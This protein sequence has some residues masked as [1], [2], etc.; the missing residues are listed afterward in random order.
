MDIS[1]NLFRDVV[2]DL[3]CP[4]THS[5]P[6]FDYL[7]RSNRPLEEN[8]RI[9]LENWFS[10][11]PEDE[12]YDLASSFRSGKGDDLQPAFFELALHELL[13]NLESRINV[14]PAL[15]NTNNK[16]DFFVEH[17]KGESFFLEALHFDGM[18]DEEVGRERIKDK[19]YD[20]LNARIAS[21]NHF[22]WINLSGEPTS[23][24]ACRN[25][26]P[27]LQR[28]I[29]IYKRNS[30]ARHVYQHEGLRI[31]FSLSPK[32]GTSKGS[33]D[34]RP[35]GVIP[36]KN[37]GS[38]HKILR[39]KLHDKARKYGYCDKPFIIAVSLTSPYMGKEDIERVLSY[40]PD[41]Q[42]T[43]SNVAFRQNATGLW[44]GN[45]QTRYTR[46]SGI[47]GVFGLSPWVTTEASICF[48]HNPFAALPISSSFERLP[49]AVLHGDHFV[50]EDGES[51]QT[52]LRM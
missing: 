1:M 2:R 5:R 20:E 43:D 36:V 44:V 42:D 40:L 10:R 6:S 9:R 23:Q 34:I 7:N 48:Y 38:K 29:D 52:L 28:F 33:T 32:T 3:E 47:L 35:I 15:P 51:L 25:Y 16:P 22:I 17:A 26:I 46:V 8:I 11:Y 41:R 37:Y 13:L 45:E 49:Q 24:P 27:D 31:E 12:Q 14:H 19:I 30:S 50:Y 39:G 18:S 4:N 21:P